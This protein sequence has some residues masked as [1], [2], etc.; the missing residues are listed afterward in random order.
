M[1]QISNNKLIEQIEKEKK[2]S[3]RKKML[4]VKKTKRVKCVIRNQ[5]NNAVLFEKLK[6][7]NIK[8]V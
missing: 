5:T 6:K 1:H 8:S 2:R 3:T 4:I 7:R